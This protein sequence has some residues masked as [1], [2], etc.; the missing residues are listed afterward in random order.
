VDL[1][2]GAG[3]LAE[4][5]TT[6][7]AH[8]AGQ[9][10]L[11]T[12]PGVREAGHA[13][14]A[15]RS[16]ADAGAA[17]TTFWELDPEPT[18]E[19]IEAGVRRARQDDSPPE[20]IVAVGGGSAMDAA[21]GI[22]FLLTN[23]GRMED[24]WGFAKAEHPLLPSLAVPTT[25]G[26][27]SDAQ[28]YALITQIGSGRKMACGDPG[29]RFRAVVLDPDVTATVPTTVAGLAG[30]DALSHALES[31][32]CSRRNETSS[33]LARRAWSWIEA[34]LELSLGEG[35]CEVVRG[36]M[37]LAAHLAGAAI[38]ASMLGAAHAAANPLTARFR[39]PHG[40]AVGL[41]LPAVIRF[42]SGEV[43][44]LYR[45]LHPDGGE[46]VA[47]R[48]EALR[49][50]AGLAKSLRDAGV[51][52]DSLADLARRATDEWTGQFN[53]RPALEKDYL[54]LYEASY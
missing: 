53:P 5:G 6:A 26:T 39:I 12:D 23:R 45:E 13:E 8:G 48:V 52:R 31:F 34:S 14:I 43:E 19:H 9:V 46:G 54:E 44:G 20:L 38:E 49:S 3:R 50:A 51:P 7:T 15:E 22:N 42:N 25:A 36:K 18:T 40:E 28:S 47:G 11:V 30:I 24:Y 35:S 27:G 41:V 4:I 29:A 37:L 17:V 21:K 32:V 16:L 2:Y 10:L 33:G 1:L